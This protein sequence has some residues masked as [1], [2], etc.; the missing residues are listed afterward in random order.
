MRVVCMLMRMACTALSRTLSRLARRGRAFEEETMEIQF[1]AFQSNLVARILR[2][3]PY[4]DR[5]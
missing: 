4:A 2:M 3:P 5:W 1:V